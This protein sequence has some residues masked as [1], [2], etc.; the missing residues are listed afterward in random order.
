[1]KLKK[2]FW[3]RSNAIKAFP[4]SHILLLAISALL[5]I[6]IYWSF[7]NASSTLLIA[8]CFAFL[9]SCLWPI[10][11]I[12]SN[13]KN[14]STINR[15]LQTASIILWGIYYYILTKIDNLFDATYSESLIYFWIIILAGILIPLL[16][17][18][19]HKKEENKI[20]FS[21]TSLIV[22]LIFWWIAWNIV[23]WWISWA[24]WSIEALFDVNI[25]SDWYSYIWILSNILLAWS[26]VF[27]YYLT[28]LE[29]INQ[30]KS[31]FKIGPSR[32]RKIFWSF[33]FLPIALIYLLIFWAYWV[34]ILV[35]GVW[36]RWIIVWLWIWYFAL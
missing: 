26:F 29:G 20:W 25:D 17:A 30:K 23:R 10:F 11:I 27:N 3:N 13:L 34:K 9:L 18:I 15:I 14:K 31:E 22:S 33:I 19:L 6:E 24:L 28:L 5:I 1:M 16:I 21:W 36:P 7:D 8:L 35:T 4:V 12:H 32:I 2:L